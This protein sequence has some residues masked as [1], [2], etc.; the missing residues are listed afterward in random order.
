MSVPTAPDTAVTVA[1][2]TVCAAHPAMAKAMPWPATSP[3]AAMLRSWAR[4]AAGAVST[5]VV[6]AVIW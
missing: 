3:V 2:A 6:L 4:W 5:N 1:G